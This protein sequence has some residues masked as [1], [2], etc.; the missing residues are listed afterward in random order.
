MLQ[1]GAG[2]RHSQGGK[3][4]AICTYSNVYNTKQNVESALRELG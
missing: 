4:P 3:A 2:L 1:V